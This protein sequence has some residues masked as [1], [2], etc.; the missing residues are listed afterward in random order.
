MV[1]FRELLIWEMFLK[2]EHNF[3]LGSRLALLEAE[4][5]F[6]ALLARF[7]D[8]SLVDDIVEYRQNPVLRGITALRLSI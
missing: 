7:P 6:G 8:L 5:V 3:C 1:S 2:E 4:L